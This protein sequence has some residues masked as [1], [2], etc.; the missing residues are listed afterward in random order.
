MAYSLSSLASN[1]LT[2][3]F[4]KFIETSKHFSSE[5]MPLVTRKG[6]YPYEYT[7]SWGKLKDTRLPEK[8]DFYS[9]LTEKHIKEEDYIH[10]K[11]VWKHFGCTT[12]GEYSDLYLMIDV[13]LLADIFENF[14]DLCLSTYQLDPAFYY[15][16]SGFSF[17]CM[18]KYTSMK[19]EL[20]S[21]YDMLLMIEKGN[22]KE[23]VY[24]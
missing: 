20:L 8:E 13:L 19:L 1:L 12:L 21:D 3:D 2:P 6:V 7:D 22:Y 15:T 24:L 5:D 18:L 17:D 11:E 9:T 10:A 16:S 14:R 23:I 4:K